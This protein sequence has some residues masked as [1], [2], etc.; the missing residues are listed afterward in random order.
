MP[1]P[2]VA[3]GRPFLALPS[4]GY[5]HARDF[6]PAQE[7]VGHDLTVLGGREPVASWSKVLGDRTIR[8]GKPLGVPWGLKPWHAPLPLARRLVGIFR[9]VVQIAVLAMFHARQDLSLCGA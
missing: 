9:A 1:S 8:G 6:V 7:V 3:V 2:D 5:C 4:R